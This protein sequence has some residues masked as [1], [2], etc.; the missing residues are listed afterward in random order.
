M[1]AKAVERKEAQRPP[2]PIQSL[3]LDPMPTVLFDAAGISLGRSKDARRDITDLSQEALP[4]NKRNTCQS[5][6]AP[7]MTFVVFSL[8]HRFNL[9][10]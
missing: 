7:R 9:A 6:S 10:G 3:L 4:S 1:L 8:E 2:N 5:S